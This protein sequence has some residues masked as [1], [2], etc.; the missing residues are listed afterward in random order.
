MKKIFF[1]F[2]IGII[3]STTINAQ[4]R[5][6]RNWLVG[7][8]SYA[9][10]GSGFGITQLQFDT[11]TMV[12][13][14]QDKPINFESMAFTITDPLDG[15]VMF[16]TNGFVILDKSNDT[17]QNGFGLSP[18]AYA[19]EWKNRGNST[20]QSVL[21]LPFPSNEQQY[22]IIHEPIYVNANYTFGF[23]PKLQYSIID[24]QANG[25]L[26][27]VTAKNIDI[28]SDSLVLGQLTAVKHANG[29]DW[30]V[31]VPRQ[32]GNGF[33]KLLLT[34]TSISYHDFQEIG[35]RGVSMGGGET[36]HFSPDGTKYAKF[37]NGNDAA[38]ERLTIAD[39]DRCTGLFSNILQIPCT[40]DYWIAGGIAISPN[41]RWLYVAEDTLMYQMDLQAA[42]I[43]AS[44]TLIGTYDGYQSPFGSWFYRGQL[45]PDGKIYWNCPNGENVMHVIDHPD[46]AGLACGFRQ[47]GVQLLSYNAFTMPHYPNYYLGAMVGSGCDTITSYQSAVINGQGVYVYPNPTNGKAS[48]VFSSK[49]ESNCRITIFNSLGQKVNTYSLFENTETFDF[50][51]QSLARGM[52]YYK[53]N[54]LSTSLSGK[55]IVEK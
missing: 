4:Y 29:K 24:M 40:M 22:I 26:G 32:P 44:K 43:V 39:F 30:W 51:T 46:S 9:G 35:I 48:F 3:F 19:D 10:Q 54:G 27:A 28:F 12:M 13:Q 7:Y 38:A 23:A 18:C 5:L 2:V 14:W 8:E 49:I 55:F 16:T 34:S 20:A 33:H 36:V 1:Y 37:D 31:V 6:D 52:Y 42:D 11:D 25:G 17:M 50:N 47:H 21:I 41:S 45:A 53:V 15:E